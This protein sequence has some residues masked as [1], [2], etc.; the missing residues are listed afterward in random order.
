MSNSVISTETIREILEGE[1]GYKAN[2]AVYRM[3]GEFVWFPTN[4]PLDMTLAS[5]SIKMSE[6]VPVFTEKQLRTLIQSKLK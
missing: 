2:Q 4:E 3:T 5:K 1:F 6:L